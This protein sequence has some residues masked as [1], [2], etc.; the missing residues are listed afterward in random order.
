MLANKQQ[1]LIFKDPTQLSPLV[2]GFP[3]L[4]A[5]NIVPG[6]A[7]VSPMTL[8]YY[9]NDYIGIGLAVDLNQ[10]A[11]T[12]TTYTKTEVDELLVTKA[13]TSYV[14]TA[15]TAK[16]NTLNVVDTMNLGT[17]VVGYPLLIGYIIIPG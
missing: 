16:Q 12:S 14:D 1:T 6:L 15:L 5:G 13:S 11:N 9:G 7:V 2:Q 4:H 3:L 8:T 17:L 10:K